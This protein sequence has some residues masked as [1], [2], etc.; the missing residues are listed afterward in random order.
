[1]IDKEKSGNISL[2]E[3]N[4]KDKKML[5]EMRSRDV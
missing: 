2:K 5:I 3:I 1:M 4:K